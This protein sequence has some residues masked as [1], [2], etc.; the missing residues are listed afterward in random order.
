[1]HYFAAKI[2]TTFHFQEHVNGWYSIMQTPLSIVVRV[3]GYFGC[4]SAFLQAHT[5]HGGGQKACVYGMCHEQW[6]LVETQRNL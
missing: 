6:D 5:V 3:F 2:S 4:C 1:M